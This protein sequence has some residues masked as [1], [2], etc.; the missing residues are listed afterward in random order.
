M[1]AIAIFWGGR[2]AGLGELGQGVVM[3]SLRQRVSAGGPG[4]QL[5]QCQPL[6]ITGLS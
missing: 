1:Y 6:S 3:K 2:E 5:K 4:V